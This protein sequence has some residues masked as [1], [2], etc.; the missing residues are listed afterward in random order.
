MGNDKL[1]QLMVRI[2]NYVEKKS[3]DFSSVFSSRH[4]SDGTFLLEQ[5]YIIIPSLSAEEATSH[6]V[7]FIAIGRFISPFASHSGVRDVRSVMMC[8]DRE[9][10]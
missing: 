8:F 1:I 10:K 5:S 6:R 2:K 9:S 4:F 7:L 3:G